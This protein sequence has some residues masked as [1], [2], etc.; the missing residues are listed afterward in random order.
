MPDFQMPDDLKGKSA[1]D[2]AQL[3]LSTKGEYD[4]FKGEWE[5]RSKAWGEYQTYGSPDEVKQVLDWSK[6][7]AAPLVTKIANGEAYLLNDADYKAYKGWADKTKNGTAKPETVNSDDDLF[8]PSMDRAKEEILA[9]VNKLIDER[10]KGLDANVTRGFKSLQDQ[11]NLFGHVTKLQRSNPNLD[12]DE[13]LK[14]GAELAQ[15]PADKLVDRLI[16]LKAKENSFEKRVQDAVAAALAE[17]ETEKQNEQVKSLVDNR[18]GAG[19]IPLAPLK[20]A[21][22]MKGLIGELGKKFPGLTE[23]IPLT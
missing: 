23:Q 5:P 22:V 6:S 4:K 2:I 3:Y 19:N 21:D 10:S 15:M 14:E 8:K 1:E 11:L 9:A 12:F 13:I 20:R 18:R 7:V 16:D 17:K